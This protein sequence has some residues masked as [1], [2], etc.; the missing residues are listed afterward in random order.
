MGRNHEPTKIAAKEIDFVGDDRQ[1]FR[2]ARIIV[3][4]VLGDFLKHQV[5]VSD[6]IMV[7]F[8]IA[9]SFYFLP[10]VIP[11]D[12]FQMFSE[13]LAKLRNTFFDR[14]QWLFCCG[15]PIKSPFENCVKIVLVIAVAQ[16][17]LKSAVH[18]F[19]NCCGFLIMAQTE[20]SFQADIE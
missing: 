3:E 10:I 12:E 15:C 2:V 5:K 11:N 19:E 17:K 6:D 9:E 8:F 13:T 20:H 14:G 7:P 18:L 4:A 16:Q 1:G